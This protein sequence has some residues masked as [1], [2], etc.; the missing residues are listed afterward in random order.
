MENKKK[1]LIVDDEEGNLKILDKLLSLHGYIVAKAKNGLEALK[2]TEEFLPDLILL[3]IMMPEMDGYET[4]QR[5]KADPAR[6]NIPIIML[7]SLTDRESKLAGL[8]VGASE[9]LTKPV[10]ITEL[11]IRV[12]HT[13]KVKEYEDFLLEY[14]KRLEAQVAERTKQLSNAF[15]DTIY[16]L[17]L[18][19]EYKDKETGAHIKR[20]SLYAQTLAQH[21]GLAEKETESMFYASPMHDIGKIGIPDSILLK[22]GPLTPEEW[23]MMKT[24]TTIGG[25]MLHGSESKILK[26]AEAIAMAHHERWDGLGYPEGLQGEA[27]PLEGRIV[28]ICDQYDALRSMRPYKPAFDHQ[29]AFEI[30]ARGD[31]RTRPEHF[32]PKVLKAFTEVAPLFEEIFNTHQD[33]V[34]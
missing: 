21:L 27:I 17:A 29:R 14:N 4:C 6:A 1:I 9:F 7:T 11:S 3:D 8:R 26:R 16:R 12:Q 15:I 33:P 20:I 24:H 13:L 34:E 19:A 10:D 30:L 5:L 23:E 28:M 22:P 25:K 32:D 2:R 18:A 31:G